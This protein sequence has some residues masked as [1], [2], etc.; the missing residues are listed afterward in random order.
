MERPRIRTGT[1]H[2][3]VSVV[4]P[5]LFIPLLRLLEDLEVLKASTP[6]EVQAGARE[7]GLA[8]GV[9]ILTITVLESA[10][11]RARYVRRD[12]PGKPSA[13]YLEDITRNHELAANLEEAIVVRDAIIHNHIWRALI[14]DY[15]DGCLRFFGRPRLRKGYGDTKFKRVRKR[16]TLFTRRL[17][18]NVFPT[19]VCRDDA[20]IVVKTVAAALRALEARKREYFPIADMTFEFRRTDLTFY[21]VADGLPGRA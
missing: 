1:A 14:T 10:L 15:P 9:V 2:G 17:R 8:A 20:R 4:G 18:L 3:Y 5:S 21:Q 11:H 7:N 16:G 13:R 12:R 6:N 19:R